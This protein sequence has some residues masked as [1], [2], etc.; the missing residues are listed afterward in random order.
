L[1][2]LGVPKFVALPPSGAQVFDILLT[3]DCFKFDRGESV[4]AEARYTPM[5][6]WPDPPAGVYGLRGAIEAPAWINVIA[7]STGE[8]DV[9]RK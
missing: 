9:P 4:R 7:P 1:E 3:K 6:T 2:R 8:D 5:K